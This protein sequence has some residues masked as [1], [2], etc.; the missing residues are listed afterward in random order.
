MRETVRRRGRTWQAEP[1]LLV[2][3]VLVGPLVV[4]LV[5]IFVIPIGRIFWLAFTDPTLGFAN[6][7]EFFE[8]PA[9]VRALLTTLKVSAVVTALSIG[10]GVLVAWELHSTRSRF[11]RL[12][13]WSAVLF[14]L[15][16]SVIVRNYAF[17]ILLQRKGI[18]NEAFLFLGL[19]DE[20]I[21]ILY[22]N[23]AV[24]VGMLYTML[25]YAILPLYASFVS[26][27]DR[28]ISA[29]ETLGASRLRAIASV[30]IPLALPSMLAAAAIVFVVS[31][32]FYITP[33]V[34][35]GPEA[36]FLASFVEQQVFLLYD[37]PGGAATG[38]IL[39][40]VAIIIVALA[41]RAVGF[42]RIQRAVA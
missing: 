25:P 36:P 12:L 27:D 34:L 24:A 41:W 7:R 35:G 31:V 19:I 3:L 10:I 8:N 5:L 11:K 15:W 26:I 13:L 42:E 28:L 39:F 17:T 9:A 6:F 21:D 20:P 14:P 23:T 32:G 30:V 33:I 37:F 38:S 40:V 16:T 4:L 18:L 1:S 22:T 29:A 2:G